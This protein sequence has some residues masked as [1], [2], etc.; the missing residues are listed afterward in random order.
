MWYGDEETSFPK[1][2]GGL[3]V[4]CIA[5]VTALAVVARVAGAMDLGRFVLRTQ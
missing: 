3:N 5:A 2:G 4:I 1:I